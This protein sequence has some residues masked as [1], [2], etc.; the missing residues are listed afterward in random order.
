VKRSP[1]ATRNTVLV[2]IADG[3]GAKSATLRLWRRT[4]AGG[5]AADGPAWPASLGS[6]GLAWG[7][8]Q[9]PTGRS[10]PTKREGDGK[11]P[12]GVF[13]LYEVYGYAPAGRGGLAYTPV[14]EHWRCVDDPASQH[15]ND[16]VDERTV[17]KDWSSAEDMRRRDDL[18]R[19]VVVVDD[20]PQDQPG[21]GSCVFLHLWRKAGKV[22]AGC[23]AMAA[24]AMERLLDR[25]VP[26]DHPAYVLLPIA[27]YDALAPHW[28]LPPRT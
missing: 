11:T 27:E 8:G 7:V 16:I 19:W 15:Y 26:A 24:P 6:G 3:W 18:Y 17:G 2:G 21:A 23:T 20:N 25:L 22:T 4:A 13:G 14:D 9:Q 28:D 12:A 10:G 5:W 1:A